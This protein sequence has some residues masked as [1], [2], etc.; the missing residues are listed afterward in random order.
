MASKTYRIKSAL[1]GHYL[2]RNNSWTA[3]VRHP[4][5]WWTS[6]KQVAK[7][8]AAEGGWDVVTTTHV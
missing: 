7:R 8:I 3:L 4:N 2:T 5:V 6:D 1:T